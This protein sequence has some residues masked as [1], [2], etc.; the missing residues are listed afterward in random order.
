MANEQRRPQG[1][2]GQQPQ[3]TGQTPVGASQP[4][5]PQRDGPMAGPDGKPLATRKGWEEQVQEFL[6]EKGWKPSGYSHDEQI[7][8]E[9]PLGTNEPGEVR[10]SHY[11]K[12]EQGN[13]VEVKQYHARP[14][15]WSHRTAEAYS[16]Q[17]ERDKW[18]A[19]APKRAK[20]ESDREELRRRYQADLAA[21]RARRAG[22]AV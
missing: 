2:S 1:S 10:H 3:G 12:D 22:V 17:R 13:Q 5:S 16:I 9:D 19:D 20:A 11:L 6:W 8:W 14:I 15:P 18:E 7:L 4:S 21:R